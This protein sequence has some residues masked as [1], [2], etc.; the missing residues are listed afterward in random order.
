MQGESG[1]FQARAAERLFVAVANQAVL[2]VLERGE[3][4]EDAQRWLLSKDFEALQRLFS[5]S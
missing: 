5:L 1:E 3:Q 2:D 4:A